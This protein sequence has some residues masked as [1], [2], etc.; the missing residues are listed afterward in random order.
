MKNDKQTLKLPGL[1]K[2]RG[3]PATGK[4]TTSA[5]RMRKMRDQREADIIEAHEWHFNRLGM[6]TAEA[7]AS[8]ASHAEQNNLNAVKHAWLAIGRRESWL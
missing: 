2:R 3:R 5:E 6:N 1:P 7:C 8:M 4:T